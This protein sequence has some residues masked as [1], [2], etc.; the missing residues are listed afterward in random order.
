MSLVFMSESLNVKVKEMGCMDFRNYNDKFE[1]DK[2]V[3][4]FR[5]K[6]NG[7]RK[8][9]MLKILPKCLKIVLWFLPACTTTKTN[10]LNKNDWIPT[11][12]FFKY[13]HPRI[14]GDHFAALTS[15]HQ[16]HQTCEETRRQRHPTWSFLH[17]VMWCGKAH[18][19]RRNGTPH[20]VSQISSSYAFN[21][22]M[23]YLQLRLKHLFF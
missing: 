22:R 18:S 7:S 9:Q 12:Y 11:N 17:L 15:I 19:P 20:I 21:P 23:T 3:I 10:K 13:I 14:E 4:D 6:F 8:R 5:K 16:S 1:F 2:L